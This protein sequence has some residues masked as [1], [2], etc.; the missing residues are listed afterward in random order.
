MRRFILKVAAG[1]FAL[2]A[3]AW[4]LDYAVFEFRVMNNRN[5]YGS[6]TVLE[7]YA[8]AEK[9]QRTEYVYKSTEQE[10]CVNALFPHSG[11]LPC[12]YARRHPEQRVPI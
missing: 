10:T 9:N 4:L 8:I 7:Y 1:F 2:V 12:W 6:V 3:F 11:F 5:P